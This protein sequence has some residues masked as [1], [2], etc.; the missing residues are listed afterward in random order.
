MTLRAATERIPILL[1][2]ADKSRFARK[3]KSCGLTISEFARMAMDQF[4]PAD[5]VEQSALEAMIVQI[6]RGTDEAVTA[7]EN[8]LTFCAASNERLST[9]DAWM[10]EK[11]FAP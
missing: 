6:R 2:K 11:G 3:A 4:D 9:L 1:T 8:A 7:V 5:A 10:R